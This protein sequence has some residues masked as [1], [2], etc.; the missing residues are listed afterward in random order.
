VLDNWDVSGPGAPC[1]DFETWEGIDIDEIS[2]Y[3]SGAIYSCSST[4]SQGTHHKFRVGG[5]DDEKRARSGFR[6]ATPRLPMTNC[7]H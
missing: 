4:F 7:I 6:L 3:S 1:L 2:P 5:N